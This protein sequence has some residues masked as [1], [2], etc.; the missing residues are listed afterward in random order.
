MASFAV[1]GV[2]EGFYGRP[3]SGQQRLEVIPRLARYGFNTFVYGPKDDPL[4]RDRWRDLYDDEGL[5]Y[6]R[7]LK[8]ACDD[9]GVE[10]W[11]LLAPAFDIEYSR[12]EEFAALVNK[13]AQLYGLGVRSFGLL[14][15]DIPEAF[16]HD[17]DRQAYPSLVAAHI[18]LTH[19]VHAALKG[20]DAANALI[21]CPTEYWGDGSRGYLPA[22][23]RAVPE[24]VMLFYTGDT[25][26]AH[27]LDA[28]N[29][30]RFA[31]VT[32]RRPLYWDNYPVNDA[33][34]TCEYHIAPISGRSVDLWQ[35]AEG[36]IANPMELLESSMIALYTIGEYLTDPTGYDAH[37]SHGRA[38]A[39][40]LGGA[41]VP[42]A[43]YVPALRALSDMCY[44]SCLTRHFEQFPPDGP[45]SGHHDAFLALAG[46]SG[47]APAI[48]G[49]LIDWARKN[50]ALVTSLESCPNL[51]FVEESRPW[52]ESALAF[53][54][55]VE[56]D[57][58]S[59]TTDALSDYLRDPLDV[60]QYEARLLIERIESGGIACAT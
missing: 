44:K 5:A 16:Q 25:I 13:Y 40:V 36:L 34:M 28:E 30:R 42:G 7:S 56:S 39:D 3:W 53:C 19:R 51:A 37:A 21:V 47:G 27:T 12:P 24:D 10:L 23:G 15:D 43:A 20:I 38:I 49:G 59:C 14:Y 41:D 2:I 46:T 45:G 31:A 48:R 57:L 52:R 4:I 6:L 55:A 33:H 50:A 60:M 22:L 35:H 17:A 32:G 58:R 29:A 54:R 9:S 11:Y 8:A 1:R 26:C 18:D